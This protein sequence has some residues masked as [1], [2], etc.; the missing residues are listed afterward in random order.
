MLIK[1]NY[2]PH[3]VFTSLYSILK[4]TVT[5]SE[6]KYVICYIKKILGLRKILIQ[7]G[8]AACVMTTNPLGKVCE[9]CKE[10]VKVLGRICAGLGLWSV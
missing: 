8:G 7:I 4:K 3:I 6:K 5:A 9:Y 1:I 10:I 2:I